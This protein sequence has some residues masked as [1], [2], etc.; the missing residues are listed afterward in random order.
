MKQW[1]FS[2]F[3]SLLAVVV[4]AFLGL[5]AGRCAGF[6]FV[7]WRYPG[8]VWVEGGEPRIWTEYT[9]H[10]LPFE[11]AG[12][13]LGAVGGV[14]LGVWLSRRLHSAR[15]VRLRKQSILYGRRLRTA[16][17]RMDKVE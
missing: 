17:A 14:F 12:A 5:L 2:L 11:S 10:L 6:G 8:S 3:A 15:E 13:C 16:A 9:I 7:G 1:T 4:G